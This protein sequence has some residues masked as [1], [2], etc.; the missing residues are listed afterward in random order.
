MLPES[1][2]LST[3]LLALPNPEGVGEAVLSGEEEGRE[4]SGRP[5]AAIDS[6]T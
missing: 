6:E 1:A 3:V 4:V 2:R 5:V